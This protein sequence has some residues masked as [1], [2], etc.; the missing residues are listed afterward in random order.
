MKNIVY[1][2]TLILSM[3]SCSGSAKGDSSISDSKTNIKIQRFDKDLYSYI[4]APEDEKEIELQQKYPLLL[5]ALGSIIPEQLDTNR[6]ARLKEYFSH[7][8]LLNIYKD[9]LSKYDNLDVYE[10]ELSDVQNI[11]SERMQGW[12]F[13]DFAMHVSG[14]KENVIVLDKMIS[15]SAD[16]YLGENYS[17]YNGFFNTSE[18]RQM[19]SK[20]IVRD[21]LRAWLI[22][23]VV[24]EQT[25]SDLLT[26]MIDEG[27]RLYI[28]SQLLPNLDKNDLIGYTEEQSESNRKNEKEIWDLIIKQKHLYSTDYEV[29]GKYIQAGSYTIAISPDSP[30]RIGVWVGWQIVNRYMKNANVSIND[31]I[32]MNSQT[33][34]KESRYNP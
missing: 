13:P 22:S 24:K 3:F 9:E 1:S 34:L 25:H 27:K 21:Y 6:L 23:D 5:R 31:L 32:K 33:I 14:F 10:K 11:I 29:I 8:M 7:P 16:K 2:I 4:I 18:R 12:K 30:D 20:M 19:N 17:G 28:L 15:I 26:A